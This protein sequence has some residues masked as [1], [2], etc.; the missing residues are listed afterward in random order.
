MHE[1][2]TA[3]VSRYRQRIFGAVWRAAFFR[4]SGWCLLVAACLVL[5]ARLLQLAPSPFLF[6][7]AGLLFPAAGAWWIARLAVPDDQ[8]LAAD[9]DARYRC[10]GL[11]VSSENEGA[12]AWADVLPKVDLPTLQVDMGRAVVLTLA[13][14][15]CL[16]MMFALPEVWFVAKTGKPIMIQS[17]IAQKEAQIQVLEQEKLIDKHEAAKLRETLRKVT[18]EAQ[19]GNPAQTWQALDAMQRSMETKTRAAW[20]KQQQQLLEAQAA[21]AL[22]RHINHRAASLGDESWQAAM[23][24]YQAWAASQRGNNALFDQALGEAGDFQ[25]LSREQVE[26]QLAEIQNVLKLSAEELAA[27]RERLERGELG[28]EATL[29]ISEGALDGDAALAAFLA[30]GNGNAR[31]AAGIMAA[32]GGGQG[33]VS[34]GPG[35]V[36]IEWAGK[37]PDGQDPFEALVLP[38]AAENRPD[39]GVRLAVTRQAPAAAGQ[40]EVGAFDG[41]GVAVGGTGSANRQQILPRHRAAVGRYFERKPASK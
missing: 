35:S 29:I 22:G 5:A 7:L 37:T 6:S 39:T 23:D 30:E 25:G 3:W 4:Y 21:A 26:A 14:W 27:L 2:V 38:R 33:A 41:Q 10:G 13:G 28:G 19:R 12:S 15:V 9:L 40:A 11:L 8:R 32:L 36:P 34:R 17:R 1:Q 31:A 16:V 24:D 18:D 20:N